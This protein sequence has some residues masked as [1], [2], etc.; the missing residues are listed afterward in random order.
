MAAL[1]LAARL[2]FQALVP[3]LRRCASC[4][5]A[6]W[7]PASA[8]SLPAVYCYST[9]GGAVPPPSAASPQPPGLAARAASADSAGLQCA[10]T[11]PP[12]GCL[13]AWHTQLGYEQLLSTQHDQ[14]HLALQH[15]DAEAAHLRAW[16]RALEASRPLEEMQVTQLLQT[17]DE[18]AAAMMAAKHKELELMAGLLDLREQQIEHLGA[19][20]ELSRLDTLGLGASALSQPGTAQ[21]PLQPAPQPDQAAADRTTLLPPG[22]ELLQPVRQDGASEAAQLRQE[23]QRLRCRLGDLESYVVLDGEALRERAGAL[24]VAAARN[25][26]E[27]PGGL[28][29]LAGLPAAEALARLAQQPP[30]VPAAGPA[31]A[32]AASEEADDLRSLLALPRGYSWGRRYVIPSNGEAQAQPQRAEWAG[33][34]A[35][36]PKPSGVSAL[37]TSAASG[38]PSGSAAGRSGLGAAGGAAPSPTSA[39]PLDERG[40]L[41]HAGW[42]YPAHAGDPL[43]AAIAALV[44]RP[45]RYSGWRAM[46]CRLDRGL[47]LC[48][49]RRMQLQVD[50]NWEQIKASSDDGRTWADLNDMMDCAEGSQRALL[51]RARSAVRLG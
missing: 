34:R 11:G 50:I 45:G 10:A 33:A 15:K 49:T 27:G 37:S 8:L 6:H 18:E 21:L 22:T 42:R 46:L 41:E 31:A 12:I 17:K 29:G 48:G 23:V 5:A 25:A 36:G 26:G 32:P 13:Q 2:S 38:P 43:D 40:H 51:E 7:P 24:G 39:A 16:V 28:C 44:N 1:C 35:E 3:G 4:A 14:H 9:P 19:M 47:Y 20:V 30:L